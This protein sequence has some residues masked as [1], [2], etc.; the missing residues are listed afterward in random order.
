M[1]N[2]DTIKLDSIKC[3]KNPEFI[4]REDELLNISINFNISRI[5]QDALQISIPFLMRTVA[6]YGENKKPDEFES[7]DKKDI[8]FDI[9]LG[10]MLKYSL[11]V[12]DDTKDI[13]S[14]FTEDLFS[15]FAHRNAVLNIWPYAREMISNITTRMGYPP[16]F[17]PHYK[18]LPKN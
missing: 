11:E 4:Q 13:V 18:N 2:L 1:I 7:I 5:I 16:L 14:N 15:Q 3:E 8:L 9:S 6:H 10:F 17:I 12:N